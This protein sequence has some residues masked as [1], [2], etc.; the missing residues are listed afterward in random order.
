MLTYILLLVFFFLIASLIFKKSLKEK[1]ILT[2]TIVFIG[3]LIF[4]TIL[5]GI[6]IQRY[7]LKRIVHYEKE[8]NYRISYLNDSVS[9]VGK[10]EYNEEN[11]D[12]RLAGRKFNYLSDITIKFLSKG[13]TIS[14]YVITQEERQI[15]SNLWVVKWGIPYKNREKIA[16]IPSDSIHFL[17]VQLI[18]SN[19][20]PGVD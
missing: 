5:S 16:Y 19:I 1:K 11:K 9:I 20:E 8:L 18:F 15:N 12:F 7:P 17:L 2:M 10:I 4:Y 6:I 3:S 14:K 13:D